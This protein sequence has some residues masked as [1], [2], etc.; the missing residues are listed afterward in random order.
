MRPIRPIIVVE[1]IPTAVERGQTV[2]ISARL[3]DK[4]SMR[5]QRVS[6]IFMSIISE[7][8]GKA[9]W[10]TE[11]VKKDASGFDIMIGTEDLKED[12][13][14]LVRVSNN[15]NFSP[16]AATRL[17]IKKKDSLLPI[18]PL[19]FPFLLRMPKDDPRK[20][21]KYIFRTQLDRRVCE[22]CAAWDGHEFEP[23]DNNIPKIPLHINCRCVMEVVYKNPEQITDDM[24]R[25]ASMVI[26]LQ[27]VKPHIQAIKHITNL[28]AR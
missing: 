23:N 24:R 4:K 27:H 18:I 13:D 9:V 22:I 2:S 25:N 8:D 14:Y 3:F 5:E 19:V 21:E 1:T 17:H 28:M 6:R 15:W 7:K 12:T 10:D 16:S 26:K 20:V 11:V